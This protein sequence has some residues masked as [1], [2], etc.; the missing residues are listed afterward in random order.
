MKKIIVIFILFCITN[1]V[2][3]QDEN[4]RKKHYNTENNVALSGYDPI[5]YFAG[6]PVPGKEAISYTY[7]G[8]IYH[9][10]NDKSLTLFKASPDKYEPAYGGWCAYALTKE[11]PALMEADPETYKIVDGKLY[12]FYNSFG[13]NTV[14]KW[15]KNEPKS[16][17]S[18]NKNWN[19]IISK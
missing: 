8:I 6:K 4:A 10:I 18:A 16:K 3:A 12:V 5:T 13:V 9:F 11:K 1:T 19:N 17:D 15:N 7:K 2:I 14:K